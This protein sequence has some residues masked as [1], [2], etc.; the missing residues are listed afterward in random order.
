MF[1]KIVTVICYIFC[2]IAFRF[3]VNG[4]ENIPQDVEMVFDAFLRERSSVRRTIFVS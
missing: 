4:I 3:K 1:Y 2:K